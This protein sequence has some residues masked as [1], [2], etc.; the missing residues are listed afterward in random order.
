MVGDIIPRTPLYT[1]T[2]RRGV[3]EASSSLIPNIPAGAY[4]AALVGLG[5]TTLV[6]TQSTTQPR[7]ARKTKVVKFTATQQG[8]GTGPT[9]AASHR[10][11]TEPIHTR[12]TTLLVNVIAL[13]VARRRAVTVRLFRRSMLV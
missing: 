3:T 6:T 5:A 7:F 9:N 1:R 4:S 2:T 12:I 10:L 13:T 11:Q 8:V